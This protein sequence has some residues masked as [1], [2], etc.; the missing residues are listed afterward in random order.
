[1]ENLGVRRPVVGSIAWLDLSVGDDL[2]TVIGLGLS[3]ETLLVPLRKCTPHKSVKAGECGNSRKIKASDINVNIILVSAGKERNLGVA[4]EREW[5]RRE[6]F[7]RRRP[8]REIRLRCDRPKYLLHL[9]GLSC[10]TA[11]DV[12]AMREISG[13]SATAT[14][15]ARM[16]LTR[17]R[18]ATADESKC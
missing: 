7:W 1:M 9:G 3:I 6:V 15:D 16:G 10:S 11:D 5:H 2:T 4:V 8:L 14:S 13:R 17:T 18:S 12:I